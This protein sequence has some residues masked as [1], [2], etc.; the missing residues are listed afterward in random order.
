MTRIL[1]THDVK[2]VQRW[3]EGN[4]EREAAFPG[5]GSVTDLVAADGTGRA[6]VVVDVDD[7]AAVQAFMAAMPEDVAAQAESHGVLM[8][9]A[10]LYVEA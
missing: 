1:I 6:A 4:A 8:S 9:T 7:L 2:D 5:G 10:V 3:L